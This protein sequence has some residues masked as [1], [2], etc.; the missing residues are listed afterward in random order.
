MASSRWPLR[1]GA[2][3]GA[4]AFAGLAIGSGLD[5]IARDDPRVALVTPEPFRANAARTMAQ[6]ALAGRN[7]AGMKGPGAEAIRHDPLHPSSAA[8]YGWSLFSAG[9]DAE[10]TA[11]FRVAG[12]LGWRD[13]LTQLY[14]YAAAVQQADYPIAAMRLDALLRQNPQDPRRDAIVYALESIPAGRAAL[15]ERMKEQPAWVTTY[16]GDAFPLTPAQSQA[17]YETLLALGR[18]GAPLGCEGIAKF[19]L[20][21][22]N[23]RMLDQALTLRAAHCQGDSPAGALITDGEFTAARTDRQLTP[24]DWAFDADGS[25]GITLGDV[26]GLSG[27]ALTAE[28]GGSLTRAFASQIVRLTPGRY[29]LTGK[30]GGDDGAQR[31][32]GA[33]ISCG[34]GVRDQLPGMSVRGG[35]FAVSFTI[36]A[37]CA[38]PKLGLTLA[39]G[40]GRVSVDSLAIVRQ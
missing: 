26:P 7:F 24:F 25:V 20:R 1:I 30:I 19:V 10:A 9:K 40:M 6:A 16:A 14:W 13:P 2:V 28:N 27:R 29:R 8:L 21:L 37:D 32:L 36:K 4:L 5:R 22:A 11:A 18:A 39:P 38:V 12:Q 15:I 34:G 17:R 33:S 35:Q 23:A 31:R 3:V